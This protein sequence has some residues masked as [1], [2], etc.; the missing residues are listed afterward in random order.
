VILYYKANLRRKV[1]SYATGK[2]DDIA[3]EILQLRELESLGFA[4]HDALPNHLK[5]SHETFL[6]H[7]Q[8]EIGG[9][10]IFFHILYHASL[11]VLYYSL[12]LSTARHHRSSNENS[13]SLL[14]SSAVTHADAIS[15]IIADLLGPSWEISRTAGFIGYAAYIASTIQLSYLWSTSTDLATS[16][17]EHIKKNMQFL[18]LMGRY[19]AVAHRMVFFSTED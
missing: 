16:A 11:A 13:V 17:K 15:N 18:H 4:W 6:L 3:T 10:F 5:Y 8:L 2:S 19:A 1:V 9:A 12:V 14:T 7:S